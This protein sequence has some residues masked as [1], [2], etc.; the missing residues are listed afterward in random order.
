MLLLGGY[1]AV[2]ATIGK[3]A[4]RAALAQID[5]SENQVDFA[6]EFETVTR[7]V[8]IASQPQKTVLLATAVDMEEV[9]QAFILVLDIKGDNIKGPALVTTTIRPIKTD[10]MIASLLFD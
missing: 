5:I 10:L 2:E 1:L 4:E 7:I 9:I 6:R 3:S 8:A